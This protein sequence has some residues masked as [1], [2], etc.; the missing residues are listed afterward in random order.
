MPLV[1]SLGLSSERQL[2]PDTSIGPAR[3]VAQEYAERVAGYLDR[4]GTLEL[5]LLGMGADGHTASLFRTD[6]LARAANRL[7]ID[8]RRPDGLD[9]VSLTPAVFERFGELM[10]VV[11]GAVKRDALGAFLR[12]EGSSLI[13]RALARC[14]SVMVW[15]DAAAAPR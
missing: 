15:C 8:V 14:T 5:G 4:G 12:G 6:D 7:A 11:S 3:A 9:G 13:G 2:L 1:A 10:V